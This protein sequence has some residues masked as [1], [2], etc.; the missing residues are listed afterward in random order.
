MLDAK[1]IA[2]H[3]GFYSLDAENTTKHTAFYS[4]GAKNTTKHTA[5]YGPVAAPAEGLMPLAQG[6]KH[7]KTHGILWAGVIVGTIFG[8]KT[9]KI[10]KKCMYVCMY[11]CMYMLLG[12]STG[13]IHIFWGL[14]RDCHL[15]TWPQLARNLAPNLPKLGPTHGIRKGSAVWRK[16]TS[17]TLM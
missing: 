13:I 2:K 16:A 17:I 4:L 15:P 6:E 10:S 12:S 11:V 5:F 8:E 3:T 1:N 7:D 14:L 9:Y